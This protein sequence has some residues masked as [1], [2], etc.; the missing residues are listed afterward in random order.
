LLKRSRLVC[1][2]KSRLPF[3]FAAL[4]PAP[5]RAPPRRMK[6]KVL[7]TGFSSDSGERFWTFGVG[8]M[9]SSDHGRASDGSSAW[10]R[11]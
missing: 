7:C 2:L 1:V 3:R 5:L 10:W 11:W 6:P 4:R 8:V 9:A